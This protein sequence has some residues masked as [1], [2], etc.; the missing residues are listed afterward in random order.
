MDWRNSLLLGV[1]ASCYIFFV[2]FIPYIS[3]YVVSVGLLIIQQIT[4]NFLTNQKWPQNF[5]FLKNQLAPISITAL[6][7][8]PTSTL[9]GS[10]IGL[11]ESPQSIIHT[12]PLSFLLLIIAIYFYLILAHSIRLNLEENISL[13]KAI[14]IAA[15]AS[16]K[17]M[18]V[19]LIMSFYLGL[20]ILIAGL[21]YGVGLIVALPLL[22]F[23][24]HFSYVDLKARNLFA[25]PAK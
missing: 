20:L 25:F 7:L 24:T 3:V 21:L 8:I 19:Y 14:D 4:N 18:R 13:P 23:G 5:S 12:A 17:N 16:L 10:A 22:F 11:L 1:I 15:L 9:L 2:R 6:V